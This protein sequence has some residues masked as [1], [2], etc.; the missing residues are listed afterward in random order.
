MV[1]ASPLISVGYRLT[2]VDAIGQQGDDSDGNSLRGLNVN[3]LPEGALVFVRNSN[4]FYK[5]KKN[6]AS[7]VAQDVSGNDNVINSI[8]SSAVN[9]RWVAVLQMANLQLVATEG[10]SQ[11]TTAGFD[12]TA[13]GNWHITYQQPGGTQGFLRATSIS[14]TQVTVFSSSATDTSRVFVTFYESSQGE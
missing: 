6:L 11:V 14:D 5:L 2:I 13:P 3:K 12:L 9:G 8:G 4:R 7:D 10:G 1:Q